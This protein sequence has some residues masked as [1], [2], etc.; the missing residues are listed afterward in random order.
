MTAD[1]LYSAVTA[2]R[3]HWAPRN[4]ARAIASEASRRKLD[5]KLV[6]NGS[7][8]LY[9]LEPMVEVATPRGRVAYGPVRA[10]SIPQCSTPVFWR[11]APTNYAWGSPRRFPISRIRS[12]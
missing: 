3:C 1:G 4:V 9:W 7:R 2:A 6:R 8:G 5:V 11:A 10:E 12:D